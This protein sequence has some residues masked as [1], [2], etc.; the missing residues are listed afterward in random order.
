MRFPAFILLLALS[1]LLLPGAPSAKYTQNLTVQVFDYSLR[2]VEGALVYVEYELNSIKGTVKTKPKPT[3]SRGYANI[4]FTNYEEIAKETNYAY[5]VYAK[6]GD[7]LPSASLIAGGGENLSFSNRTYT[8]QVESYIAFVRVL[9]Q[10]GR[11]LFANVTANGNTKETGASGSTFFALPPGNYT[12]KVERADLVKNLPLSIANATG[13]RPIDV[14]LSYYSLD[15]SVMDDRR[16]PLLAQVEVNGVAGQTGDDGVAHFANITVDRPQVIVVYGQGI[17]RLTPDLAAS[18]ALDVVFDV[19]KPSIK[20]QY[21]T[22]SPTGVGTVRFFVEDLGPEASGID[23]VSVSY[24]ASGVQNRLSV[25]A[26]GYNSFEAKIPA[27]PPGTLVKYAITV[28]DKAGNS[29]VGNGNYVAPDSAGQAAN[30]TGQPPP[31]QIGNLVSAEGII[32]GIVVLAVVAFAAIYYLNK[33]KEQ[34]I[35]PPVLPPQLPQQ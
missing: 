29:V 19:N 18:P 21:S 16:N 2:P 3:D 22:L 10:K 23:T 32:T 8:L 5:T 12:V 7:Q 31:A 6:Y 25:Y 33:R 30:S 26:I 14:V 1:A 24:E 4:L 17:Q 28:S 27:Q 34:S 9:D 15:V 13:D 11:P 20:E 35:Q